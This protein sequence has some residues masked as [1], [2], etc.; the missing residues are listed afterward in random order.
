MMPIPNSDSVPDEFMPG[1]RSAGN[2]PPGSDPGS[3]PGDAPTTTIAG[4]SAGLSED[5]DR[6]SAPARA[7]TVPG[8]LQLD[9][10]IGG[11]ANSGTTDTGAGQ[12]TTDH[13]RR[14]SWQ[15]AAT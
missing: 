15:Q 9:S 12:G 5:F 4:G 7:T 3:S 2:L 14:L 6:I 10:L 8:Q 1:I 13:W 11:D